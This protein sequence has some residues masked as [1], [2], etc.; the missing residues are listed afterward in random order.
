MLLHMLKELQTTKKQKP[1]QLLSSIKAKRNIGKE[2][3]IVIVHMA[4]PCT[5]FIYNKVKASNINLI[6]S[7]YYQKAIQ[8]VVNIYVHEK[9]AGKELGVNVG[10]YRS[11]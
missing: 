4:L 3:L 9:N 8:Y 5:I 1:E 7:M 6:W 2:T 11:I 10:N